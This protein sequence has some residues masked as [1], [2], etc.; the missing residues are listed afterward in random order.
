METKRWKVTIIMDIEENS[1]PSDFVPYC[2][3]EI[4]KTNED[5]VDY[6]YETVSDDFELLS[7]INEEI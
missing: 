7:T 4:I 5:I 3:N 1:H 2:L 6:E